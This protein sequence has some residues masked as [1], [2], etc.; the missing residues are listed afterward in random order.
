MYVYFF[1]D[2]QYYT[3]YNYLNIIIGQIDE[4]SVCSLMNSPIQLY[5]QIVHT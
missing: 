5:V 4:D 1:S 3:I 2:F